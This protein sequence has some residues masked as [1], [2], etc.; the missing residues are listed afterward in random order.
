METN[1]YVLEALAREKLQTARDLVARR[2]LVAACRPPRRPLRTR[3]G[4]MLIA[5]GERLAGP[6]VP[7][8][9]RAAARAS[10]G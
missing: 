4:R 3:L 10:R 9:S 7:P 5:L 6:A 1:G 8:R 2:A